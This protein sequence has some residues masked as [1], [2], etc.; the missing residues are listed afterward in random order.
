MHIHVELKYVLVALFLA[1][2]VF[3]HFRGQVRHS[4]FRRQ[5]TDH[6]AFFAPYNV[7][8][9]LFSAVPMRP[10]L[11]R[12]C[13][14][15]LAPLRTNWRT[16][17]EEVL[18]LVDQGH[19]C[20]VERREDAGF[21]SFFKKGWKRFHLKWYGQP[22]PSAST[23]CPRTVELLRGI[24]SVRAATF[25]LLP[26]GGRL[27]AHRDPFAGSLRYHLGL[28]TP[29][30]DACRIV[31]DGQS[32]SWRD[33]EDVVFDATYVH[34]AENDTDTTRIILFCDI[35]RPLHTPIMRGVNQA[36]GSVL[37]RAT[38]VRNLEGEPL[39]VVNRVYVV[40]YHAGEF[41]KR[42]KNANRTAYQLLKL[43]LNATVIYLLVK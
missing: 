4:F 41:A 25:A 36:V 29:N 22:L 37:G 33:G 6:S 31:V 15:Q 18:R 43:A 9:Y 17:R 10:F 7:L 3:I 32:Y 14:P 13:F 42:L 16:I 40:A 28:V 30:S 8:A 12:E 20:G 1:S 35:E 39:G 2:V 5:L 38:A 24:P 11:E 26:P 27:S 19:V 23:F 21:S 34:Q